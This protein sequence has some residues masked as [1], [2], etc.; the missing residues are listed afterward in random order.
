[1]S[2]QDAQMQEIRIRRQDYTVGAPTDGMIGDVPVRVGNQVTTADR[3]DDVSTRT[4]RSKCAVEVDRE[5]AGSEGRR[6]RC[7]ILR[8]DGA[9][10]SGDAVSFMAPRAR[11]DQTQT[12]LVK[13][14]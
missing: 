1:M 13:G 2:A 14:R 9:P 3:A 11:S 6:C 7:E 12:V 5:R 8:A 10:V 4:R